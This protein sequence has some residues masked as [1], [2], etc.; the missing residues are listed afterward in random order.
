MRRRSFLVAVVGLGGVL[1]A[2]PCHGE[3]DGAPSDAPV[4]LV[5][6]ESDIVFK[7]TRLIWEPFFA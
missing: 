2:A 6:C 1:P 7:P 4:P 5:R 3:G